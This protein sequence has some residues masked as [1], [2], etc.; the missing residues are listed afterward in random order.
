MKFYDKRVLT[1]QDFEGT[2]DREGF[3]RAVVANHR[4]SRQYKTAIEADRYDAQRNTLIN[5]YV[6]MLFTA[7]GEKIVDFTATNSKMA[8]NFFNRLNVQR[9]SYSL[10]KG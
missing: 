7:T 6:K 10:G 1:Y 9:C 8:S 5:N 4:L 2:T 3:V